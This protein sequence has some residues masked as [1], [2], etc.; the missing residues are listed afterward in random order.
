VARPLLLD[1]FCGAGGAAVGYHRAG[2]DV[3]GIDIEPQPNYPFEFIEGDALEVLTDFNRGALAPSWLGEAVA[4][5]AS[6]PCQFASK[7]TAWRGDRACHSNL[8]PPTRELLQ[9]TGLPYVIENVSDARFWLRN[10]VML[11]GTMFGIGAQSHRWFEVNPPLTLLLPGCQHS[12]TDAS[13]DHGFKQP[14]SVFRAVIG[15][16]W[17]TV[18]EARQAVLP[19]QTE[20]IG[21]RLLEQLER[22]A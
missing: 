10:P 5:H 7:A 1:L 19:A 4:I 8:I 13:R 12:K 15:C 21:A 16:D 3:V 11:C 18:V 2:F 20:F 6:P 17:M 9:A 14:E 22:V